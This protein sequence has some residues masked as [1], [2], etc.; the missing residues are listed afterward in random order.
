MRAV[1]LYL[2]AA[3]A[4]LCGALSAHQTRA[5]AGGLPLPTALAWLH[6]GRVL[7]YGLLGVGAGVVGQSL[8]KHLPS[9]EIGR[10]IQSGA[11]LV[12][13]AIG[14]RLLRK[15]PRAPT[16]CQGSMSA[17]V[18]FFSRNFARSGS[19]KTDGFLLVSASRRICRYF[20]LKPSALERS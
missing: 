5:A 11:A 1:R 17:A 20:G 6:G 18:S 15:R 9:P 13:V 10:L 19:S 14:V 8:L 16:C 12:L 2:A 7:G 3:C 4:A